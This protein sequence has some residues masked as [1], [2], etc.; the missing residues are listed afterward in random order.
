MEP[1]RILSSF[2]MVVAVV[3][4]SYMPV[5]RQTSPSRR[6][7]CQTQTTITMIRKTTEIIRGY[8]GSL[9][10]RTPGNAQN[11]SGSSGTLVYS[12]PPGTLDVTSPGGLGRPSGSAAEVSRSATDRECWSVGLLATQHSRSAASGNAAPWDPRSAEV[13]QFT[14]SSN[15][16]GVKGV[17]TSTPQPPSEKEKLNSKSEMETDL[18]EG[19]IKD[20]MSEGNSDTWQESKEDTVTRASAIVSD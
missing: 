10:E 19:E 3:P 18:S 13:P 8:R 17:Y 11:S 16:Q 6:K 14:T 4:L 9:E 2:L 7:V 1:K 15:D 12:S 5:E 20:S